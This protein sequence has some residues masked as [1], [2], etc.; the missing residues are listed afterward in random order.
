[1]GR[2]LQWKI[3]IANSPLRKLFLCYCNENIIQP[4]YN[5]IYPDTIKIRFFPNLKTMIC[6]SCFVNNYEI[7]KIQL[8]PYQIFSGS[9]IEQIHNIGTLL[10]KIEC[11]E[12]DINK[13]AKNKIT[14]IE[15]VQHFQKIYNTTFKILQESTYNNMLYWRLK[16]HRSLNQLTDII[17]G[18]L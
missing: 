15:D 5:Y 13:K 10:T 11:G 1:M 17:M 12:Y 18:Y 6:L 7:L 9:Y 8:A 3:S 14:K 16:R 2:Y 4:G